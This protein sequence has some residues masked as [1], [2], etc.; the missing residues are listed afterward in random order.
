[1]PDLK[2]RGVLVTRPKEQSAELIEAITAA[3]GRPFL[4]S[5]LDVLGRDAADVDASLEDMQ[6]PDIAL[7]VSPNAV[8]FGVDYAG[9]AMIGAIG[10]A[11][12]AALERAGRTVDIRPDGGYDSEHLLMSDAL[13]A[14]DGKNVR[15][16]RG[17][18]GR[19][20]L[21]TTLAHRGA[22][23][24]YL[25]V[26]ARQCPSPEPAETENLLAAWSNDEIHAWI[27]M[28][29]ETLDNFLSLVG[30][31][32]AELARRTPLVS[33]AARVINVASERLPGIFATVADGTSPDALLE[34]IDSVM[35]YDDEQ[36][37]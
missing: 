20:L 12:A 24:E 15:I 34:T 18:S 30:D 17:Q 4:Y 28:S 29:V 31:A 22:N 1:M 33:P 16:I 21:G 7:F 37:L 19:E 5:A 13:S 23:V 25:S 2:G 11:T 14:I 35:I 36:G 9:D 26:Y 8:R 6:S 27:I 10:P 32:G 3:G